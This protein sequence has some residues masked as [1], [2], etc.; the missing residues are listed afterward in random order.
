[1]TNTDTPRHVHLGRNVKR[2]R[3]ILNIKQE[4]LAEKLGAEWNQQRIS[5]IEGKDVID[6][7]LLEELA[8]AMEVPVAAI[9]NFDDKAAA[10]YVNTFCD[11]SVNNGAVGFSTD[12][13]IENS[14][15]K[16]LEA[17]EEIKKLNAAL[18]KEKDEKIVLLQ[19]MVE[20]LEKK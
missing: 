1:M 2:L 6:A 19:K 8:K 14:A 16:L 15:E 4:V 7:A 17:L 5:T 10:N 3:E 12:T 11:S 20:M 9:K 18:L 13:Y